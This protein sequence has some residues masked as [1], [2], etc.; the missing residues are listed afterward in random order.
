MLYVN[1]VNTFC[2]ICNIIIFQQFWTIGRIVGK[3]SWSKLVRAWFY[4]F[5]SRLGFSA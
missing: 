2:I 5:A 1:I 4:Q 3:Y